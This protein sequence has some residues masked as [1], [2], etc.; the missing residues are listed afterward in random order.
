M[1]RRF[2]W[3]GVAAIAIGLAVLAY[4][5]PGRAV[6]RGHV[7]DVAAAMLVYALLGALWR[8]RIVVRATTALAIATAIEIGQAFWHARSLVGELT[9]GDTCDAW[10]IL[11]YAIGVSVAVLWERIA[12]ARCADAMAPARTRRCEARSG[13]AARR[14][15]ERGAVAGARAARV[16]AR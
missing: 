7:G 9:I 16:V 13:A 15:T 1:K 4:R 11:A 12:V 2:L 6:V 10:D 14:A 3:L 8:A 5:G